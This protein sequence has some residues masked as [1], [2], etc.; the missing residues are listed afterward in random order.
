MLEDGV[1]NRESYCIFL[2][3]WPSFRPLRGEPRFRCL[4]A[5]IGLES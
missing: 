1:V 2:K 4:L 3:A 5:R